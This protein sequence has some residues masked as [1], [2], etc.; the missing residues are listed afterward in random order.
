M[1]YQIKESNFD[2]PYLI[3]NNITKFK[4]G[5]FSLLNETTKSLR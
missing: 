2:R 5:L 3:E 1:A 4:N